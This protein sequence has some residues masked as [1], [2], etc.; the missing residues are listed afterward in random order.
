MRKPSSCVFL[1]IATLLMTTAAVAQDLNGTWSLETSANLAID[2]APGEDCIFEGSVDVVQDG[3]DITGTAQLDLV[4]GVTGCPG[5]L[6]ADLEA[7]FI[8][9]GAIGVGGDL[10]DPQLG[11]ASF[12]GDFLTDGR[13]DGTFNTL[14]GPFTG[15]SGT[16]LATPPNLTTPVAI[17]TLRPSM[18]SALALF[19]AVAAVVLLLRRA[20]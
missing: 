11:L 14:Q 8:V 12:V 4:D 10:T 20:A 3:I 18:L 1:L 16:F 7:L 9:D 15:S 2:G 6:M 19:L 17:P 13:L 5:T